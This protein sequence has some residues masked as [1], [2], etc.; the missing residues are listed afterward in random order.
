MSTNC[1]NSGKRK[2]FLK[3]ILALASLNLLNIK[4]TD[5][6]SAAQN[7][8]STGSL[9]D[10][11]TGL[12]EMIASQGHEMKRLKAINDV[13]NLMGRYEVVHITPNEIGQTS[14]LFALW[15]DDCSVEVSTAGAIFG[16]KNI[17]EYWSS[18][19]ADSIKA[20]AFF[21]TLASPII[22]IAGNGMTAKATWASPGFE[23]A[24][25]LK[26]GRPPFAAWC[27]GKYGMDFIKNPKTGEWKIW[28]MHWFRMARNDY[29]KDFIKFAQYEHDNPQKPSPKE[30]NYEAQPTVFHRPLSVTEDTHPF[31]V[32][33]EPYTDYDGDF[34]WPYGGKKLEEKYGVKYPAYEKFYNVN[35]P[36][37]V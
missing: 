25:E 23:C 27:W 15:R 35:Y 28:H 34:R 32:D 6:A 4:G 21:H 31:P 24:L 19:V 33:P 14:E 13:Q 1:F 30:G 7:K 12:K 3:G 5:E 8:A 17:R 2:F 22:Q 10:E 16:P 26:K 29:D 9:A 36:S 20:T 11:V 37:R 18:M